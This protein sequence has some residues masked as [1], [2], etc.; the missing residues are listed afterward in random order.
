MK[1]RITFVIY[2]IALCLLSGCKSRFVK[3]Y[4]L[5]EQGDSIFYFRDFDWCNFKGLGKTDVDH[6]EY[7]FVKVIYKENNMRLKVYYA[8]DEVTQITFFK[9]QG[10]W[11]HH[12]CHYSFSEGAVLHFFEISLDTMMLGL[13]YS[14]DPLA[15]DSMRPASLYE[16]SVKRN[17]NDT[18]TTHYYEHFFDVELGD[19]PK[20]DTFN[21]ERYKKLCNDFSISKEYKKGDSLISAF[22]TLVEAKRIVDDGQWKWDAQPFWNQSIFFSYLRHVTDC[23]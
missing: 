17:H 7:P 18:M 9:L 3:D 1:V 20:L 11:C 16:V 14:W 12:S 6:L 15:N 5:Q 21:E 19:V 23:N 22:K 4:A 8:N 10:R 13:S 2:V